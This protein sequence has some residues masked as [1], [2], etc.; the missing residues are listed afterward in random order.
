MDSSEI[1]KR[2][3]E[4]VYREVKKKY[5]RNDL[6]T[7]IQDVLYYR[8]ETYMKLVSF[9]NGKRIKKLADPRKFEKFMDTKGVKIVAE[10]LDGLNNQ[11]KMQA[12]EYK[13]KVLTKVRQGYQK[14]NHPEF[15]DLKE[16]VYEQLIEKSSS[17]KKMKKRL[18]EEQDSKGFVYSDNFDMQLIHDSCGIDEDVYLDIT[19]ED[20]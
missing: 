7:R 1:I 10:V 12:M 14:K 2:V 5:T 6:D 17:Y 9:A 16:E 3:R 8:T 15:E 19:L 11:P 4:R 13:Q 18:Y 20:Y